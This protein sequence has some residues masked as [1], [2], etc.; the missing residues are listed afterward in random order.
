[1]GWFDDEDKFD[2]YGGFQAGL[3]APRPNRDARLKREREE[4]LARWERGEYTAGESIRGLLF[5]LFSSKV[6]EKLRP[7]EQTIS[8]SNQTVDLMQKIV[9]VMG[10]A[11]NVEQAIKIL[12]AEKLKQ[13][14]RRT[15]AQADVE[16]ANAGFTIE[17]LNTLKR[18]K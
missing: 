3:N 17:E 4:K 18:N 2:P 5:D 15:K 1:M 10:S 8:R 13:E 6:A 16:E 9:N 7:W 12:E 11:E 14:T